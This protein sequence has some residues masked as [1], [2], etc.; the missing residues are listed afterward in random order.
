MCIQHSRCPWAGSDPLY[1]AYHDHEWGQPVHDDKKLFEMLLL[2]TMQAGL[3]WITILRKREM[4]RSAFDGF[5]PQRIAAY[6]TQKVEELMGNAG[7]VRNRKKIF[8]A[9][10]NAAAFLAVQ[11]KHGSFDRWLWRY[12]GDTPVIGHWQTL[13]E[14]PTTTE[15]SDKLS[16]DM[17]K[18][19]FRFVGSTTIYAYMQAVGMVN[20]HIASC[21]L[22]GRSQV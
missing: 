21:F 20:D 10:T 14:V 18:L 19:G 22:C 5:D 12:V 3:S 9:I 1:V 17:K 6:G 11:E 7:I 16:R 2:E 8:A 4:Y 13:E 15:I